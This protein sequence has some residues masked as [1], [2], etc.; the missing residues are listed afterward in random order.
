ME[1]QLALLRDMLPELLGKL[2]RLKASLVLQLVS[3][4]AVRL[5][6][7]RLRPSGVRCYASSLPGSSVRTAA[8]AALC[9]PALGCGALF[10][11]YLVCTPQRRCQ[12]SLPAYDARPTPCAC[13]TQGVAAKLV[14]LKSL[15]PF[16]DVPALVARHVS[17]LERSHAAMSASMELLRWEPG[18]TT[19]LVRCSVRAVSGSSGCSC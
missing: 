2:E 13:H 16:T 19:A 17:V 11:L 18:P 6:A 14:R 5:P 1:E 15:L 8:E 10:E 9:K 3:D 7:R 4:T 12:V